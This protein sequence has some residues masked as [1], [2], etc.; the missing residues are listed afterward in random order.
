MQLICPRSSELRCRAV[1][2]YPLKVQ[3]ND[4]HIA[5][6]VRRVSLPVWLFGEG[7]EV[8]AG[9]RI[10]L[11]EPALLAEEVPPNRPSQVVDQ[12]PIITIHLDL[13][14][15]GRWPIDEARVTHRLPP[16]DLDL[17][18]A[19]LT[20][21]LR[22]LLVS[23]LDDDPLLLTVDVG[24]ALPAQPLLLER[25][26]ELRANGLC[27]C[28]GH[29]DVHR[30]RPGEHPPVLG[31]LHLVD[32]E[33]A[34]HPLGVVE[35]QLHARVDWIRLRVD[36]DVVCREFTLQACSPTR[37]LQ[38]I[39]TFQRALQK[40]SKRTRSARERHKISQML[41]GHSLSFGLG[42]DAVDSCRWVT[43]LLLVLLM[44][45][46]DIA[47]Q[48]LRINVLEELTQVEGDVCPHLLTPP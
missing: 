15:P 19:E 46:L 28:L 14:Q 48:K 17:P 33:Q 32:R 9:L 1:T 42:E 13:E 34:A 2:T 36:L 43:F 27:A 40:T 25:L 26:A 44:E 39:D 18:A 6:L 11:E 8:K 45:P 3:C 38:V 4:T 31:L 5:D 22:V 30:L 47:Y 24:P 12:L 41:Q 29:F 10:V 7:T 20:K 16:V 21:G 37:T 23:D 35:Q